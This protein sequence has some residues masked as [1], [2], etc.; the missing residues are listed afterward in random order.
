MSDTSQGPGWW[1]AA[2]DKWY[3]PD[4]VPS[5][6][7]HSSLSDTHGV[8]SPRSRK[9]LVVGVVIA[10]VVLAVVLTSV[11]AKPSGQSLPVTVTGPTYAAVASGV[12]CTLSGGDVIVSGTLTGN[13]NVPAYSGVT[14][15]A[16]DSA[17]GLIGSKEGSLSVLNHGESEAFNITVSVTGVPARCYVTWGAGPPPGYPG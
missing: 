8:V 4:E 10:L 2:D 9:A 15:A 6:P 17:G 1:Q 16:Y 13:A 7:R 5:P 3:S 14:A 12:K 11:H